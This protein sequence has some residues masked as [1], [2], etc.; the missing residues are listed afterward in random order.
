MSQ[1]F[2]APQLRALSYLPADGGWLVGPQG[3]KSAALDSLALYHKDLC[4][5]EFGNF[6]KRGG[7]CMRR[8]LTAKGIAEVQVAATRNKSSQN[9]GIF[10]S[11]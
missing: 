7:W 11:D 4:E 9:P 8:R 1:M 5:T 3:P 6:G 10:T 2:T